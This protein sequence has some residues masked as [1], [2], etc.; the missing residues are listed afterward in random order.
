MSML[1]PQFLDAIPIPH[2]R[3]PLYFFLR[4]L[5]FVAF[6]MITGYIGYSFL[7]P[8]QEFSFDFRN[9]D[10]AKNTLLDPRM[11]S[12]MSGRT[13]SVEKDTTLAVNS[14]A[15]G[16]FSN[17]SV[18]VQLKKDSSLPDNISLTA[19]KGYREIFLPESAPA[20]FPR[21]MSE[22]D[23]LFRIR[24]TVY[25]LHDGIL[26]RFASEAAALSRYDAS[27]ITDTD[28]SML[29]QYPLSDEWIGFR[30][31][32][33]IS[34]AD[35]VFVVYSDTEV[36][37][38][39]SALIFQSLGYDWS[40]VIPVSEEDMGSYKRGK[41]ILPGA[42]HAPGTLFRDTN[43]DRYF[44][45]DTQNRRR[46]ITDPTLLQFFL[47]RTHAIPVSTKSR[48]LSSHCTLQPGVFFPHT[49]TCTLSLENLREIPESDYQF[50]IHPTT[51]ISI[52][53]MGITLNRSLERANFR[54]TLSQLKAR[55]LDRYAR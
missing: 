41:I 15:I 47:A 11:I 28:A 53:S 24:D 10:A 42:L 45:I 23:H 20:E 8:S 26:S 2:K 52:E 4:G 19:E 5:L 36:R 46:P 25:Q 30:P 49:Y 39:G 27:A 3:L 55:I 31:G 37:P 21:P 48:E 33:L 18:S 13:G 7:F 35:G 51:S 14:G 1:R 6:F 44:T 34:F 22:N 12:G 38:V 40:D 43:S 17:A 29:A 9:P 16:I 32:T 50:M 54:G